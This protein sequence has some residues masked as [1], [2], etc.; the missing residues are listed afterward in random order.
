MDK[1]SIKA[2]MLFYDKLSLFYR[3][4]SYLPNEK[5]Q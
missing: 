5:N 1:K 3:N 4:R 2:D